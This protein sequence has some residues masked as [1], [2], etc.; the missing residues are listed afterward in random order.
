MNFKDRLK[1]LERLGQTF[2]DIL[3]TSNPVKA[4]CGRECMMCSVKTGDCTKRSIVYQISCME[5]KV[6]GN[7]H[8]YYGE[9][10]RKGWERA[11]EHQAMLEDHPDKSALGDHVRDMHEGEKV[12]F[13]MKLVTKTYKPLERQCVEAQEIRE[14]KKGVLNRKGEWGQNLPPEF[15]LLEDKIYRLKRKNNKPDKQREMPACKRR[16]K[17]GQMNKSE[18]QVTG[19]GNDD[20]KVTGNDDNEALNEMGG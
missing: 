9:T 1:Y 7:P 12:E 19:V 13:T 16:R 5:C 4:H 6:R 3:T 10:A 14:N 17:D 20:G 2:G 8:Y 18:L 11:R 15:G